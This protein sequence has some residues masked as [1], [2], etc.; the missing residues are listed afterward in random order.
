MLRPNTDSDLRPSGRFARALVGVDAAGDAQCE[1][2]ELDE[3]DVIAQGTIEVDGYGSTPVERAQ[4][5]VDTIRVRLAQ[6]TCT[7]HAEDLSS[8]EALLGR[9]VR[10]CPACGTRL[11]T[12]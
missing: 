12:G 5:I 2:R 11:C 4:F 6:K 1:E 10:W 9:G 7:L 8:I 3:G